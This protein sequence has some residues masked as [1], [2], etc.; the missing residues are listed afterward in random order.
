MRH[1]IVCLRIFRVIESSSR[2]KKEMR[3]FCQRKIRALIMEP[4]KELRAADRGSG[5]LSQ[6]VGGN[7]RE[8]RAARERD[9][10]RILLQRHWKAESVFAQSS[11]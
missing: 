8:Q 10:E 11:R 6:I 3:P 9:A 5:C 4:G 7:G 2:Q 1:P